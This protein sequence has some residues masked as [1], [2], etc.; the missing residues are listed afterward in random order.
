MSDCATPADSRPSWAS[1]NSTSRVSAAAGIS[2]PSSQTCDDDRP[3]R[4][5]A[6]KFDLACSN[7]IDRLISGNLAGTD[8]ISPIHSAALAI[9]SVV[10]GPDGRTRFSMRRCGTGPSGSL[11]DAVAPAV[12]APDRAGVQ[13]ERRELRDASGVELG[14]R[15]DVVVG[16]EQRPEPGDVLLVQVGDRRRD[17]RVAEAHPGR[18]FPHVVA[19]PARVR[20][21]LEHRDS[22]LGPQPL[23]EQQ[24]AVR[25]ARERRA[26]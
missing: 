11:R 21:L 18:P 13:A 22:G 15:I 26:G 23:A 9:S 8:R 6:T 4:A 17:P 7:G 3:W 20:R 24:R 19:R 16:R 12:P 10:L 1:G 14:D 2:W 5:A 25:G